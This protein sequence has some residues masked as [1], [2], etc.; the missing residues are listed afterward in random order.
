MNQKLPLLYIAI[1]ASLWGVIGVFVTYLYEL[2]FT[3]I[4][5]VTI[6]AVSAAL[7]LLIYVISKNKQLVK[8]KIADSK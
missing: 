2:G 4:Q 5:V 3:P 1:G 7:F 8:I 6:R